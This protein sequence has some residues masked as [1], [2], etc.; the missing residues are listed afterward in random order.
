MPLPPDT[1][2]TLITFKTR[3]G[4]WAAFVHEFS[5]FALVP[6]GF[7]PTPDAARS[8]LYERIRGGKPG[9]DEETKL[10]VSLRQAIRHTLLIA[11]R[12]TERERITL[13]LLYE[14]AGTASPSA[15]VTET[16]DDLQGQPGSS[17]PP[18]P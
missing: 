18:L 6:G 8:E 17:R 13:G 12:G 1:P 15:G 2:L 7:G 10:S 4:E 3:G 14:R 5:G 11:K 16:A 9:L